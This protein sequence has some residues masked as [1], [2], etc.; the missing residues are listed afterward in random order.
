MDENGGLKVVAVGTD[1]NANDLISL[2]LLTKSPNGK[3]HD[4]A[5]ADVPP[6]AVTGNIQ[7][8]TGH[9][10]HNLRFA[11]AQEACC[12]GVLVTASLTDRNDG[13][14]IQTHN[15]TPGAGRFMLSHCYSDG[16]P[17]SAGTII[18][19]F[20]GSTGIRNSLYETSVFG[21]GGNAD[22]VYGFTIRNSVFDGE[23]IR[24]FSFGT[25]P[26]DCWNFDPPLGPSDPVREYG[27]QPY[28][29]DPTG[30]ATGPILYFENKTNG[31]V[32]P[33]EVL[34][35]EPRGGSGG[36]LS[37]GPAPFVA[38]VAAGAVAIAPAGWP[39]GGTMP[40]TSTWQR[41]SDGGATWVDVA[42]GTTSRIDAGLAP[43]AT[44]QYRLRVVDAAGTTA[45]TA[46]A[47]V[48]LPA[49][50]YALEG[51]SAGSVGV[52]SS[53]FTVA[54][55]GA[56]PAKATTIVPTA[57]GPGTFDPA[58]LT[59]DVDHPSGT[60][61]FTPTAVGVVTIATTNDAGLADPS[62]LNYVATVTVTRRPPRWLPPRR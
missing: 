12:L 31:S 51:P 3:T 36:T 33:P 27:N 5:I 25:I 45:T 24:L 48:A 14:T 56:A 16:M 61:T 22:F 50:G 38:A 18:T 6:T 21:G 34:G 8:V 20:D 35:S 28:G 57:D 37:A 52:T 23:H 47:A 41:S 53:P 30:P 42:P 62:P 39:T 17:M 55:P 43:G 15:E 29:T 32:I 46:P 4:M 59:L 40:R 26:S 49:V 44:Y 2:D 58:A 7:R 54:F 60:F 9:D 10:Q 1:T 19:P 11:D 13:I